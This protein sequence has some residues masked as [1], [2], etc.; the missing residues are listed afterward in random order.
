MGLVVLA[1]FG[2]WEAVSGFAE[3]RFLGAK[4]LT[5]T[6]LAVTPDDVLNGDRKRIPPDSHL[7]VTTMNVNNVKRAGVGRIG[8]ARGVITLYSMS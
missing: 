8:T 2:V 4:N 3:E 1:S 7:G 6:N 5:L